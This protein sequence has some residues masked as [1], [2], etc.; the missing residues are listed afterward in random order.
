MKPLRGVGRVKPK[1]ER[2]RGTVTMI[3]DTG[4]RTRT[5]MVC[6]ANE[7]P[8]T[9]ITPEPT[10]AIAMTIKDRA[11]STPPPITARSPSGGVP[12]DHV[13][14][15]DPDALNEEV[16]Q[17]DSGEREAEHPVAAT[18]SAGR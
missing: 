3:A 15:R 2:E 6:S 9:V 17:H 14:R 18:R 10:E 16:R 4:L 12:G 11:P 7:P 8:Q 5:P 13:R 1:D